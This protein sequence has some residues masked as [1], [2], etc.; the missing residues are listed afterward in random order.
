MFHHVFLRGMEDI[1]QSVNSCGAYSLEFEPHG[2]QCIL[3]IRYWKA[4]TLAKVQLCKYPLPSDPGP[5]QLLMISR[6]LSFLSTLPQIACVSGCTS[7]VLRSVELSGL[8]KKGIEYPFR[9]NAFSLPKLMH[10]L[11][12]SVFGRIDFFTQLKYLLA[13]LNNSLDEP[14]MSSCPE[15]TKV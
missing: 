2:N 3:S 9:F 11:E 6:L 8:F 4:S 7:E 14:W 12:G 10:Q 15:L 5:S 1:A 13:F